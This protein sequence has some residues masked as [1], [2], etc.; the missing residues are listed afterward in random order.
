V[1]NYLMQGVRSAGEAVRS[2]AGALTT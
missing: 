2:R 1:L